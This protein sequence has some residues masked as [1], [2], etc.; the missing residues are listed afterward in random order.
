MPMA[1]PPPTIAQSAD[2]YPQVSVLNPNNWLYCVVGCSAICS[3]HAYAKHI[4]TSGQ[5]MA[6]RC[7]H[8]AYQMCFASN[9]PM[10]WSF[11]KSCFD[12]IHAYLS[13]FPLLKLSEITELLSP[14]NA[15]RSKRNFP[16]PEFWNHKLNRQGFNE[17][18]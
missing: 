9:E 10:F 15:F 3:A 2:M 12:I 13:F 6:E 16:K 4:A 1:C 8:M 7:W 5:H 17:T 14:I 18:W 11:S